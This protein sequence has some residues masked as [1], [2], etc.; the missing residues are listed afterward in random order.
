M[1]QGRRNVVRENSIEY[2]FNKEKLKKCVECYEKEDK[3]TTV[4]K[5]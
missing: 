1:A 4:L 2:I 3:T 5:M